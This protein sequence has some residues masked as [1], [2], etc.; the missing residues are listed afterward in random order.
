MPDGVEV[1]HYLSPQVYAGTSGN[2]PLSGALRGNLLA[3]E[4][5]KLLFAL[6]GERLEE[7]ES[8]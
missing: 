4:L 5:L 7:V 3:R 8:A 1:G 6:D 2:N